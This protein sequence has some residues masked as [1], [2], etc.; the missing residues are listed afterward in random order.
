MQPELRLAKL[1]QVCNAFNDV[2]AKQFIGSSST[3]DAFPSTWTD[4]QRHYATQFLAAMNLEYVATALGYRDASI[5]T[6]D[7]VRSPKAPTPLQLFG[8]RL[9]KSIAEVATEMNRAFASTG[10]FFTKA[11]QHFES[12]LNVDWKYFK[13]RE[14]LRRCK[15]FFKEYST[16]FFWSTKVRQVVENLTNKRLF[17]LKHGAPLPE[18]RGLLTKDIEVYVEFVHNRKIPAVIKGEY[19]IIFLNDSGE[20]KG[21]YVRTSRHDVSLDLLLCVCVYVCIYVSMYVFCMHVCIYIYI[22]R[23]TDDDKFSE[24]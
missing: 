18:V 5:R 21:F 10:I 15:G 3:D 11:M 17:R 1:I 14:Y 7:E 20:S 16:F 2:F 4:E 24:V 13:N 9:V 6:L 8:R 12:S 22:F 23:W 19:D